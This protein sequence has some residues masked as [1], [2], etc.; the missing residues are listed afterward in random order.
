MTPNKH[1]ERDA[2]GTSRIFD[3]RSLAVDYRTL[4]PLLKKGLHVLDVGCGTGAISKDIAKI[5]GP[6]GKVIGIDNTQKFI[7][8]GKLSYQNV[9]NLILLH[10]DIFDF[11]S[12]QNF[13]LIVAARM[14][15]WLSNPIDALLKM[16]SLLK[17]NG[18]IS[19][20]DYN[21]T[22]LEWNP[23]PPASMR[24]YYSAFLKWRADA[25][26]N[27]AIAEDL[28]DMLKEVGFKSVEK[29][30]SNEH[31]TAKQQDFKT[32]IG[33]WSKVA[34]STQMVRE[35]YINDDLRLKAIKEYDE[36]IEKKAISMTMK[37]NEVRGSL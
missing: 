9:E 36:W 34:S 16:K 10:Q 11:N 33:I 24:T 22:T 32:R 13:D 6:K 8:S 7:E 2:E 14:L 15:Q 21:H 12:D 23:E 31:Y 28:A 4:R 27:N 1:I 29:I 3:D 26:M 17:P 30:N 20:L 35:G 37:L 19:I 25:G 18:T 5:V